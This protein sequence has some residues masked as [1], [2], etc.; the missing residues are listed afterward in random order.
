M[1][2]L[3]K[4]NTDKIFD[5]VNFILI[6][7]IVLTV[8][9]PLYYVAIASISSPDLI[10][11]GSVWLYPKDITFIGYEKIMEDSRIWRGYA[12]SLFYTIVGTA[13]NVSITIMA[14]Y[15]LSR[16]DFY[17][18]NYVMIFLIITM[19]LRGGLIP[20]FMVVNGLNLID[21]R[22]VM[23]IMGAATVYNVIVTRSFFQ[24]NI[25][26]ELKD[27]A[28]VDGCTNFKFFF[29]IILPLS[30][31]IIAVMVVFYGVAHWNQY[32]RAMIYLN[33]YDL[34]P[35][36]IILR[37]ILI[38]NQVTQSMLDLTSELTK[39]QEDI[40]AASII[41]YGLIIVSS[42]PMLILYPVAQ[43][44]FVKGVMIGSIKG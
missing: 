33:S 16:K 43:K 9:Y 17:I 1:S 39:T 38:K 3:Y 30:K 2:E 40:T 28:F 13:L 23:I 26:D 41:K 36:Q 12:N 19:Y 10:N 32:F 4:T 21:T 22:A 5:I 11:S 31:A 37:E 27:A 14:G 29:K 20:E 35:L 44:Y 8:F 34:Y 7:I 24:A 18:R 42:I 25:P 6:T 15:A